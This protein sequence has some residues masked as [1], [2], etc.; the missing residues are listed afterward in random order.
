M[1]EKALN[2]GDATFTKANVVTATFSKA[3]FA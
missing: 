3:G 2:D 1:F